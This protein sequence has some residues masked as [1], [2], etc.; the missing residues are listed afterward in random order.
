MERK[1][2]NY[3]LYYDENR[4]VLYISIGRPKNSVSVLD[5]Q[6]FILRYTKRKHDFCGVTIMY[7]SGYWSKHKKK[8]TNH[9]K[10]YI[11]DLPTE[12]IFSMVTH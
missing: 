8:F 4:D 10:K 1:V 11:K 3:N 9:L 2:N 5:D 7:L 12:N 6:E